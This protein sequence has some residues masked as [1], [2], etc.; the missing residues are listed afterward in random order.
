MILS[1][2]VQRHATVLA[3]LGL[4]IRLITAPLY[5]TADMEWWK[6][7]GTYAYQHGITTLYGASDSEIIAYIQSGDSLE[8]ITKKTQ[9][10]LPYIGYQTSYTSHYN[11]QPPIYNYSIYITTWLYSVYDP[12][13]SN[14]RAFNFFL[15]LEPILSA[16]FLAV[17]I[18]YFVGR[19]KGRSWGIATGLL[20]WLHPLV[21]LNA[22]VQ[23][24]RDQL[25]SL[26]TV[27][28]LISLY[29]RRTYS[30]FV[31]LGLSMMSKPQGVLI[32]PVVLFVAFTENSFFHNIRYWFTSISTILI[33]I[34]PFLFSHHGLS[35]LLGIRTI[36]RTIIY[37]SGTPNIWLPVQFAIEVYRRIGTGM[38]AISGIFGYE[39]RHVL[40]EGVSRKVGFDIQWI[41]YFMILIFTIGNL[42][43]LQRSLK[44]GSRMYIFVA[45]AMQIYAYVMLRVGVQI[46]HYFTMIPLFTIIV[47]FWPRWWKSYTILCGI[48]LL[49][50][51]CFYGFGRDAAGWYLYLEKYYLLWLIN[52]LSV[53]NGWIFFSM[54][55]FIWRKKDFSGAFPIYEK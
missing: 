49:Y 55:Y 12:S 26:F 10:I 36:T 9:T 32:A 53:I 27:L 15:N 35:V 46:N 54:V 43:I 37:V 6:A 7:F 34:L 44:N 13:L 39:F 51:L 45:A 52:I 19:Q 41:G 16:S 5:G 38:D 1:K 8:T 24:Y 18:G 33:T 21:L 30:S 20:Y 14:N 4:C 23:G 17:I 11:P 3:V 2:I 47:G 22:P 28:S 40:I 48:Y 31:F 42:Y 50:D 25:M 29:Q